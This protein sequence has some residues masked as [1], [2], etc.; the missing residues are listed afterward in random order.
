M[1]TITI[2]NLFDGCEVCT[3]CYRLYDIKYNNIKKYCYRLQFDCT[4]A[5][6]QECISTLNTHPYHTE[7]RYYLCMLG[8]NWVPFCNTICAEAV[9]SFPGVY[10]TRNITVL[11]IILSPF[12][13]LKPTSYVMHQQF[14]IQQLYVL[15]TLYLCVL[16]LS[17]NKQRLVP[18]T[19][20]LTGF[21]N[22]DEKVY[23]V[24]RTGSVNK[25]VCASYLTF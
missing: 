1:V 18:L 7:T 22:R 16:Y 9:K 19:D 15:P 11:G 2:G 17:E 3:A 4:G 8:L 14:N 25:A 12:K 5:E 13:L 6:R 10:G 23:C 24:V 20:K 21:Y